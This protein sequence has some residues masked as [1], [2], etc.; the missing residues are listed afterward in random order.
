MSFDRDGHDSS[1]NG[2][3][4]CLLGGDGRKGAEMAQNRARTIFLLL[5]KAGAF[6]S[7]VYHYF[8][9]SI[10]CATPRKQNKIA[11]Y[12]D[13]EPAVRIKCAC[14]MRCLHL[15]HAP[16]SPC[17]VQTASS[18]SIKIHGARCAPPLLLSLS[19]PVILYRSPVPALKVLAAVV[20][21]L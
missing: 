2:R 19:V 3:F 16:C 18:I 1:S 17:T 6:A 13:S 12:G 20:L 14:M 4:E 7:G 11:H 9:I 21:R 10:L 8:S 15:H 5:T